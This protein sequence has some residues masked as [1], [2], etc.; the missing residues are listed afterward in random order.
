MSQNTSLP[1][2]RGPR[3]CERPEHRGV[4]RSVLLPADRVRTAAFDGENADP[5]NGRRMGDGVL[6]YTPWGEIACPRALVT[7][8]DLDRVIGSYDLMPPGTEVWRLGERQHAVHQP[9]MTDEIRVTTDPEFYDEHS[10]DAELWSPGSPLFAGPE[11]TTTSAEV[12]RET[13]LQAILNGS[14]EE[15]D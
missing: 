7:L 5:A 1:D 15:T 3:S 14:D 11:V 6:D 8:P 2:A 9:G 13:T 10:E 12:G 4:R